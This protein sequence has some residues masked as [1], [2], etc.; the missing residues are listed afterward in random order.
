MP[1]L[2]SKSPGPPG[3]APDGKRRDELVLETARTTMRPYRTTDFDAARTFLSDP[4][5]MAFWPRPM[6]GDAIRGWVEHSRKLASSTGFGRWLIEDR[7]TGRAL[8]DCGLFRVKL[9][10]HDEWDLGYVLHHS[11]WRQGLGTECS[12][13]FIAY[14]FARPEVD[15]LVIQ[16]AHDHVA[17]RAL[18]E[19]LGAAHVTQFINPRNRDIL[20]DL[21]RLKRSEPA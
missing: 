1:S 9:L 12:R 16:M 10:G 11:Q 4:T 5:T 18:A 2:T 13:A 6:D 8:G 3:D 14:A 20:T 17:S 7:Q 19:T 21:Y 15:S